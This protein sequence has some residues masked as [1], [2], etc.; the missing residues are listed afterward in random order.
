ML[1]FPAADVDLGNGESMSQRYGK[2]REPEAVNAS[3]RTRDVKGS[4]SS[5]VLQVV[6]APLYSGVPPRSRPRPRF[7]AA[8]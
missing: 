6:G 3:R 1:P 2:G 7:S 5:A 8:T 4:L